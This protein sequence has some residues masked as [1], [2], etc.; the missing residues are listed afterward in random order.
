M[1]ED[2]SVKSSGELR[3]TDFVKKGADFVSN[4]LLHI[5]PLA[6]LAALPAIVNHVV[7][8]TDNA[9]KTRNALIDVSLI[10]VLSIVATIILSL[11]VTSY[12][13]HMIRHNLR[14]PFVESVEFGLSKVRI[15]A[16]VALL[17]ALYVIGGF[18]LF[19]IPGIIFS[20][21]YTFANLLKLDNESLDAQQALRDSKKLF[22]KHSS[23]VL[24]LVL[25]TILLFIPAA[26]LVMIAT[27]ILRAIN[28]LTGNIASEVTMGLLSLVA[29]AAF[30][31]LYIA[32]APKSKAAA[33]KKSK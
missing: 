16:P 20:F 8:Y 21:W 4:N 5:L 32:I 6:V 18:I 1:K 25:V 10:G 31:Y 9:D 11:V 12:Y 28:E 3:S 27:A 24:N 22:K 30:I 33:D 2:S 17:T 26:I 23:A 29:Q 15:V 19:I 13:F 7:S 14:L